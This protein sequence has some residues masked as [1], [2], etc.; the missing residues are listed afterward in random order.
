MTYE[1]FLRKVYE[2]GRFKHDQNIMDRKIMLHFNDSDRAI[3]D[4]E[5]DYLGNILIYVEEETTNDER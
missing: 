1:E 2:A 3:E 4:M 5:I